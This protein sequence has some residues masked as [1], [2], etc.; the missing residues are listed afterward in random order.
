MKR[1]VVTGGAG[2]IGSHVADALLGSG[3]EVLVIDDLSTGRKENLDYARSKWGDKL[4]LLEL[5]ICDERAALAVCKFNPDVVI[6]LAAQMN[7]RKSVEAPVFDTQVNVVGTVN[8][9][10]A[11][12]AAGAKK[13]VFS[14]TGGAIYGE[15][16]YFP[17]DEGHPIRPKCPY[18]VSKRAAELYMDY[19]AREYKLS[20][21]A[22]RFANVY[23][24]RQNPFGEAGVVAIFANRAY[25]G[26][27]LR[28]NGDG[29]QTRDYV[30]VVDVVNAVVSAAR[31]QFAPGFDV[32]NV[33]TGIECS[34]NQLVAG[35]RAAWADIAST[36]APAA[37]RVEH[38]PAMPGEQLRSVIDAGKITRDLGWN[39]QTTLERGLVKTIPT[40][41]PSS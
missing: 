5:S 25:A 26:Q 12:R 13:F 20:C 29:N 41:R 18:G 8:M 7:V 34:V 19:Y 32:F 1:A 33:G 38:G 30:Y 21:V 9:V 31:L 10:E 17:A 23:G 14:S 16:D 15:Q 24:P 27:V 28:V 11:A 36:A 35:F 39:V 22:L 37:I 2:F 3:A 40:F 6:H 4:L